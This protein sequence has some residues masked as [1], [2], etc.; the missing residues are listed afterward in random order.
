[1]PHILSTAILQKEAKELLSD[2]DWKIDEIEFIDII[3]LEDT[4]LQEQDFI[5]N[6]PYFIFT[7]KQ[8][9]RSF[10]RFMQLVP[11]YSCA[12]QVYCLEG[13]TMKEVLAV[14][15]LSIIATAPDAKQLANEIIQSKPLNR[16]IFFCS[17]IRLDTLPNKL[18][19]NKIDYHELTSYK[20]IEKPQKIYQSYDAILFFSPSGVRSFLSANT[21]TPQTPIFCMGTTTKDYCSSQGLLNPCIHAAKPT[22]LSLIES[23]KKHFYSL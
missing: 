2:Q 7:S 15:N 3:Y 18:Q 8:G 1:M 12:H 13:Q 20:T 10:K 22:H 16:I 4:L 19:E 5:S 6:T 11:D 23:V 9:V 17:S 21:L 14:P